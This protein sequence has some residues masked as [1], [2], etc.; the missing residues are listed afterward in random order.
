MD[1][2]PER[3]PDVFEPLR[4][5]AETAAMIRFFSRLPLPALGRFDDPA[6]PPPFA[7]SIRML[8]VAALAIAAPAAFLAALL[9]GSDLSS[10][11]VATLVVIAATLTT[12]AFHEDG[13]ADVADAFAGG[14][15]VARRLEIM[16]DSR[17]GAFGAVALAAQFVLRVALLADLLDRFEAGVGLLVLAVAPLA[18]VGAVGLMTALPPARADGLARAAGRPEP[19]AL[20]LAGLVA[21]AIFAA[22]AGLVVG[23]HEAA[24]A[25]GLGLAALAALAGLAHR[26][27]G[28]VTGDVVGAGALVAEMALLLGLAV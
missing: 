27:I 15:T 1:D 16:K 8:P 17:V 4:L 25:L 14:A 19:A 7:R 10:L 23:P 26:A 2:R 20:V 11:V 9:D 13:L 24:F 5:L 3:A 18:R 22:L 12:G 6:R 21:T 28:G